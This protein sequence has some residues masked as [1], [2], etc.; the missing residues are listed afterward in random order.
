[1]D[2]TTKYVLKDAQRVNELRNVD[3]RMVAVDEKW[4]VVAA[5]DGAE[6]K[7]MAQARTEKPPEARTARDPVTPLLYDLRVA[8]DAAR[9]AGRRDEA[10][11]LEARRAWLEALKPRLWSDQ[12]RKVR[13]EKL[14]EEPTVLTEARESV[15]N[16]SILRRRSP[17][18]WV[19][20]PR[21]KMPDSDT[22]RPRSR[23]HRGVQTASSR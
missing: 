13:Q 4:I 5:P 21:H 18:P 8:L 11:Q 12:L 16:I 22:I 2:F 3:G 10:V 14:D 1:M 23:C 9:K 15:G 19:P 6:A 17:R 20:S 7:I